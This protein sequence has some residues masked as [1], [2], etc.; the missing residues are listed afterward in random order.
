MA[1]LTEK[2]QAE[3]L[4]LNGIS[5]SEYDQSALQVNSLRADVEVLQA[6]IRKTEVL[7]PYD[8]IVGLRNI[9]VGAQ[10]TPATPLATIRAVNRL[11]LDFSV[12]EKYSRRIKPG[13]PIRFTV[14]GEEKT[15]DAVVFATEQGI[16]TGTRTL[17]IR[18]LVEAKGDALLPGAFAVVTLLLGATPNAI[19]IPTQAII[20]QER[21]KKV[22]VSRQGKAVLV[23]V[24]TGLRQASSIEILSGL[25]PGDTVATTGLPFIKP[26]MALTFSRI[27]K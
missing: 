25:S 13:M 7:A 14:Q 9:S 27:V 20:P 18:A 11:R 16:E 19:L 22:I 21:D 10:A 26:G 6:Q 8:G 4:K 1:E 3:L 24:K 17:K 12:P 15:F 5:Q 23:K 2:R